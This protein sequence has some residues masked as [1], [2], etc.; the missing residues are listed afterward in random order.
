MKILRSSLRSEEFLQLAS[1]FLA[2]LFLG[3]VSGAAYADVMECRD[4]PD[5]DFQAIHLENGLLEKSFLSTLPFDKNGLTGA[6]CGA[7]LL[8]VSK[9]GK[10]VR[11]FIY[12]NGPDYFSETEG[13][14]RYV[15]EEGL[16]GYVDTALNIVI[17]A[18]FL[19]AMPFEN[20]RAWVRLLKDGTEQMASV[21]DDGRISVEA[22]TDARCVSR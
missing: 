13:L 14:A 12:D 21:S 16:V 17:P 18:Q 5:G 2:A 6:I 4:F 11:A 3:F 20:G 7:H 9:S 22:Q 15:S 8:H 1:S 10:F 19:C